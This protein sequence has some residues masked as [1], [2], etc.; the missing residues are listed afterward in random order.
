MC[1]GVC[2]VSRLQAGSSQGQCMCVCVRGGFIRDKAGLALSFVVDH[3]PWT[4]GHTSSRCGTHTHTHTHILSL[5]HTHATYPLSVAHTHILILSLWH[6]PTHTHTDPFSAAGTRTHT[7]AHTH[8]HTHAHAHKD[9]H[10][11]TQ[12]H[13]HTQRHKATTQ[14]ILS[15]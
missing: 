12:R 7:H 11:R 13:T 10:T 2:A 3:Q 1:V 8:T 9:T 6:T 5:W 4:V 14:S 15:Q